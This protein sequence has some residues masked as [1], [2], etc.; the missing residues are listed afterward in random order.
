MATLDLA[1]P[2]DKYVV[3]SALL[4]VAGLVTALV[5]TVSSTP[6][7]MVLFLGFGQLCIALGMVM[8]LA[9]VALDVRTRLQS[10]VERRFRAGE[11]VFRQGDFPDRLYL[12]GQGEVDVIRSENGREVV[13]A[14]LKAGE[15]FGEMGI[16]GN[17]PR[18][19]TVR[20]ASDL[21]TLSIHRHYFG[22]LLAYV[23]AWHDRLFDDYR[24]RSGAPPAPGVTR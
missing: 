7:T 18:T 14:R 22:P 24:R 11:V 1:H 12:I 3:A 16:L 23:P 19:A 17:T 13:L 2:H 5:Y 21:E 4:T 20:A 9:I 15:F 6:Y 10:V 8:L